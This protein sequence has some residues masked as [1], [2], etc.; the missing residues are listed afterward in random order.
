METCLL[1]KKCCSIFLAMAMTE[2]PTRKQRGRPPK[3]STQVPTSSNNIVSPALPARRTGLRRQKKSNLKKKKLVFY[4]KINLFRKNN[5]FSHFLNLFKKC[6][7]I[8]TA[9]PYI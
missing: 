8:H 2:V 6:N 1:I 9:K 5:F 4:F 3:S 7:F